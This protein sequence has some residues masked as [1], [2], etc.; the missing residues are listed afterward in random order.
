QLIAGNHKLVTDS[1]TVLAGQALQRGAVLGRIT[2][3]GKYVLALSAA[4]DGS[5]APAAIACDYIDATAGDAIG[6][7]YLAGEFNGAA[8]TLGA[9]VTLAAAAAALRPLS[10]YIKS[11]V[12]ALDPS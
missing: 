7:I 4:A 9:G 3:S 6:G 5:Q 8:L 10:I 12:T 2:A 1:V 11:S